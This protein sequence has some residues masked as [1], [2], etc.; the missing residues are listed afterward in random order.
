MTPPIIIINSHSIPLRTA[1][2]SLCLISKTHRGAEILSGHNWTTV[3]HSLTEKWPLIFDR[4]PSSSADGAF[5]SPS[6]TPL[7]STTPVRHGFSPFPFPTATSTQSLKR[8]SAVSCCPVVLLHNTVYVHM[9][10]LF[11]QH[12]SSCIL[13]CLASLYIA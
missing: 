5:F 9:Q 4:I 2:Y 6:S 8:V 1:Y 13:R 3:R 12:G 10:G 11:W 7:K